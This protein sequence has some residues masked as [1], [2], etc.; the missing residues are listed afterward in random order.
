MPEFSYTV[1]EYDPG[2]PWIVLGTGHATVEPPDDARF[3]TWA[4]ENWPPPRWSVQLDAWE[5]SPDGRPWG[6]DA[7][8][9]PSDTL[10]T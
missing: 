7:G 2:Q 10:E 1:A 8:P 6:P 5:L 3:F 4:H 9:P